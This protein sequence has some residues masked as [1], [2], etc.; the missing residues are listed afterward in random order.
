MGG[1]DKRLWIILPI[2]FLRSVLSCYVF[3]AEQEDP[4]KDKKCQFGA[5]CVPSLDGKSAE[6]RCP[7]SCPSMG[8]HIGSR[9]VCG[10]D[11]LDYR[12]TCELRRAACLSNS[13]ITIKYQGKCGKY[14]INRH[15]PWKHDCP[16]S[17]HFWYRQNCVS[18]N[19]SM[20]TDI[21]H[22]YKE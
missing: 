18:F 4:C 22:N 13:E 5:R 21:T 9:P 15:A 3:P 20:K 11:G 7:E 16:F 10:S 8:D 6:C 1:K 14:D 2:V 17:S 19:K 12:D